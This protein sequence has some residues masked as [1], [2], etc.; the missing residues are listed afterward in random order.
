MLRLFRL[1][2]RIKASL[3]LRVLDQKIEELHRD[4]G[5]FLYNH[6]HGAGLEEGDLVLLDLM[7]N[8]LLR[9]SDERS[10]IEREMGWKNGSRREIRA[11]K[12]G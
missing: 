12:R 5:E 10:L 2:D 7:R 3:R 6:S 11:R 9:L 1:D 8:E 4:L